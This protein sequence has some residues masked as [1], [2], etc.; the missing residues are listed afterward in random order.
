[1][2][3]TGEEQEK[4]YKDSRRRKGDGMKSGGGEEMKGGRGRLVEG[5]RQLLLLTDSHS[6]VVY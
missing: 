5:G 2:K 3:A 4:G 6:T 1:M